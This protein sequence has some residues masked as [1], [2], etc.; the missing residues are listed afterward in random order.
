MKVLVSGANGQLGMALRE[1]GKL[2]PDHEYLFTDIAEMD[3]TDFEAVKKLCLEFMPDVLINCASYNAVDKAE[4][5]PTLALQINAKAVQYLAGLA[6]KHGFG[7][8]HISTDYIFDGKK[9][10]AYTELDEPNPQ[11]KY[12]H[13]KFI[14]EQAVNTAGPKAAIIRTSWL[15]SEYAH[16][17]VKTIIRLAREKDSLRVVND[18]FGTPTYAGDLAGAILRML[19][20][21]KD[22]KGVRTY[23]Y[24]NEGLTNWAEFAESIITYTGLECTVIPVS[25]EE[26]GL[27]K[28]AR[29]AYSLL[30]KTK[31]REDFRLTIPSWRESLKKCIKKLEKE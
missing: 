1:N 12:A 2:F 5:E 22:F 16:N 7:L 14:G 28:A 6:A 3:V 24:S 15:Y 19:P 18:Q 10:T 20:H 29:P 4:D 27:A 21:I 17:F 23:N 9:G 31:I 26:Y 25:T 8:I 30:D 13:S 11:S